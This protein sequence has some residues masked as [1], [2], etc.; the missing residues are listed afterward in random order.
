MRLL[1][2]DMDRPVP[3]IRLP[4]RTGQKDKDRTGSMVLQVLPDGMIAAR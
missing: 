1:P 3:G 2:E 4:C